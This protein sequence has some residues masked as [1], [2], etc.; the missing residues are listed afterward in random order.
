MA[1]NRLPRAADH[2]G[3]L[4]TECSCLN[5]AGYRVYCL[6]C[7]TQNALVLMQAVL[8][9]QGEGIRCSYKFYSGRQVSP[10]SVE[11]I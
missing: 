4:R 7:E 8:F 1:T 3:G 10:A 5:S 9:A 6:A 2:R 11:E